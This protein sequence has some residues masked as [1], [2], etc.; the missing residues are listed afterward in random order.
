MIRTPPALAGDIESGAVSR[1]R[2]LSAIASPLPC[3]C[4]EMCWERCRSS[5]SY[6][7]HGRRSDEL[8]CLAGPPCHT[9]VRCPDL[10][11]AVTETLSRKIEASRKLWRRFNLDGP[12][13]C[14]HLL[15]AA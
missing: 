12:V 8:C 7:K 4:A 3:D 1:M 14:C 9:R 2:P 11:V 13:P 5:P 10:G 15:P 6:S